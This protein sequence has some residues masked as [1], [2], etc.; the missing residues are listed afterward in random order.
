M[1][2]GRR[3]KFQWEGN[4][5]RGGRKGRRRSGEIIVCRETREEKMRVECYLKGRRIMLKGRRK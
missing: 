5:N 4:D 3:I 2:K 1:R